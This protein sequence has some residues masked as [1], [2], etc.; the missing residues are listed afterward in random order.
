[1][2]VAFIVSETFTEKRRGGFGWLVR[3]V[4][5]E[6]AKRGFEVTVLAWRDPGCPEKYSVDGIEVITYP[7]AFET[8]SVVRHLRD[9]YGFARLV[10]RVKADIFISIEAMVE[11]LIAEILAHSAKHVVWAQDPFD[12][13]DYQLLGSVDPNYRISKARFWANKIV[14]G[15]AYRRAD[16]VLSQARYYAD[17]LRRL[18]G[19]DPGRVVYLPNPV[20]PIPE[21]KDLEKGEEPSVCYLARMDPQKRYWLFFELA[22]QFPEV[23]FIAMGRPNVLY[24]D[25]YKE[26]AGKYAGLPNLEIKGFVSEEEKRS[27][28]SRCWIMV[29]PSIREGL[30]IAML[31][32]LAHK[33]ALLS[34]VNPGGL[35]E[36]FGYWARRDDF[37]EGLKWLLEGDRWRG[38]GEEGYK[39]VRENHDM[40]KILNGFIDLLKQLS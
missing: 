23:R 15:M 30:P 26:I 35:T 27:I 13:S 38:L 33:C 39:Y 11:T 17:K 37:A 8:K 32:A 12:W 4:G 7:Y 21:G 40:M 5:R 22:K 19:V 36:R 3:L 9:Y 20:D 16:L 18:Y 25:R 10:R 2:R 1:M 14:F 29:L 24:E 31:E 6:L 34:S 28:L